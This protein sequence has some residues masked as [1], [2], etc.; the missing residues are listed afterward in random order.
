VKT[1][2][3]SLRSVCKLEKSYGR[4][5]GDFCLVR[6][7]CPFKTGVPYF[8]ETSATSNNLHCTTFQKTR[9]G[10]NYI[11]S[12]YSP[13]FMTTQQFVPV[14]EKYECQLATCNG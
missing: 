1:P 12:D 4:F 6:Q 8:S 13:S 10:L 14:L 11:M 5:G 3:C 2:D 9:D 7:V